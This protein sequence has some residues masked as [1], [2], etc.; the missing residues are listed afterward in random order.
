MVSTFNDRGIL[1]FD[2]L[3][4]YRYS[5]SFLNILLLGYRIEYPVVIHLNEFD[6]TFLVK[7][8]VILKHTNH[9]KV[10]TTLY[11]TKFRRG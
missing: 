4:L 11:M 7:N 10:F 2:Q 8:I 1:Y 3:D 5:I 6:V 9:I